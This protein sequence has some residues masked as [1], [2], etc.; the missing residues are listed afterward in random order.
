[1][2]TGKLRSTDHCRI[3]S[4]ENVDEEDKTD[5]VRSLPH[6]QL[7]KPILTVAPEVSRSL[8]HRQLRKCRISQTCVG[9]GSLPHRQLRK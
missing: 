2:I 6:R 1:M 5:G 7:R 4:L 8:P 3:G 9:L